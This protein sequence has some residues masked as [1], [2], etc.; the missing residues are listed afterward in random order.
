MNFRFDQCD[1]NNVS[2]LIEKL[3]HDESQ[4]CSDTKPNP[5]IWFRGLRD[6]G[7]ANIPTYFRERLEIKTEIYRMNLFKQNSH[8]LLTT[9][10]S[11]EWEWMFLMRH[12]N[13]PSRLIDW[14]ENSLIGLY[15][16]VRPR[17]EKK[18]E[19]DGVI[20]FM[21]PSILNKMT[22]G[23]PENDVSLPM[24]TENP[25]EYTIGDNETLN[26]YLPSKM[27][28]IGKE[29]S[30]PPAAGICVRTNRRIQAQMGV[31]TIHH[32]D[33]TP[34][35]EIEDGSHIWRCKIPKINKP[36]ILE[37]LRRIG[38]TERTV[39]PGLDN[40]AIEAV[41]LSGVKE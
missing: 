2:D 34:I 28:L 12:H 9:L 39:F 31:F 13:L 32:A 37:D 4:V 15:F 3:R 38:I 26:N 33:G 25:A 24:F 41:R 16:A 5:R 19:T 23:W 22:I 1:I 29:E 18:E 21:L 35:E 30:R 8:E 36:N 17:K 11:S 10:P 40:V 14:T 7:N 6:I 20:W 27:R